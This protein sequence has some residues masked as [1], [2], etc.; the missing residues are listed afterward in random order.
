[1]RFHAFFPALLLALAGCAQTVTPP[2]VAVSP[3]PA[4]VPDWRHL[5][6]DVPADLQFRFGQLANGMRYAIRQNATPAGTAVVRMEIAS[7][8]LSETESERGFAHFVEH[9]AFNGSNNV[10]EGEMIRLLEREGLA[11]GP[12]TNAFT[13]FEQ[14]QY[15]LDLPRNDP[16]LLDTA[17]MLMRE[18]A[19][20]L[21]F[22]EEAVARERGVILAEKRD[23]NTYA[24]R[25]LEDQLAFATPGARYVERLPIGTVETLNAATGATLRAFWAREYVPAN[26][27][28]IVVGDLPIEAVEAAIHARFA[29][30]RPAPMPTRPDPGP[31]PYERKDL[32]DV[33]VDPALSERVSAFRHGPWQEE[34]DSI[35]TRQKALLKRIGYEVVNRRL[36]RLA[37][38]ENAAFRSAGLGTGD[39][40]KVGRTTNLIVDTGDGEWKA[41][42][43]AAA[44]EYRRALAGG[45]TAAEVAEQVA[46][47]RTATQDAAG[48]ADTRPHGAYVELVLDLA[49]NDKIPSTPQSALER[50]EAF[51]P[52]ITPGAVMAALKDELVPL[53]NPLLRFQGRTSPAGGPDAIRSVWESAMAEKLDTLATTDAGAFGYGDFGP[54]GRVVADTVEPQLGIRTIRFANGVRLNL[55]RTDVE[56][57]RVWVNLNL[58]G[59][60]MLATRENPLAVEMVTALPA[61]GLGKHSEDELDSITAGR[62]VNLAVQA[63]DDNFVMAART[64]PRDL[65]LQLQL[66]AAAVT[67]PGYRVEGEQNYR[68]GIANY[69]A[70]KDATPGSALGAEIG[71]ILSDG[72]PRFTLQPLEAYRALT[73]AMLRESIADRLAHGA[74]ELALVGDIDEAHAIELVGRTFGALPAREPDFLPYADRRNRPFTKNLTRR[75]LHHTGPEDQAALRYVWLTTDDRDPVESLRLELLERVVKLELTDQLREKL[76]KAYSP[77]AANDASRD[78]SNYGTFTI[79]VSI[80]T[81]EVPATEAAIAETMA[82]L[83]ASPVDADLLQRARQPMIERYDNALKGNG[84]WMSLTERAQSEPD[85]IDRFLKTKARLAAISPQQLLETARR[86]LAY[87]KAVEAIALPQLKQ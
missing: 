45:F 46:I 12:D 1:M 28:L 33:Y 16:T 29:D 70:R 87:D 73:F 69:F 25:E 9:M 47:I 79:G 76:G 35:A 61:G 58:D 71:G 34:P 49:R 56:R 67:D 5:Q 37:R 54:S 74:I 13:T 63:Q 39:V 55:K 44:R 40:F 36:K 6:G 75:T 77:S 38:K 2:P 78:W 41:G 51:A 11:F 66:L 57:D 80:E 4:P 60:D 68:R 65:E 7:G 84:G 62:S 31:V 82:R 86:Y 24:Y 17:L 10:P 64:T 59:G 32:T 8:S 3:A 43:L 20:E 22:S 19:S 81:A 23:R 52:S 83:L 21:T 27:T 50:F 85:R 18:T 53:D 26:T 72:D 42:L 15:K 48:A 30:W 14:T